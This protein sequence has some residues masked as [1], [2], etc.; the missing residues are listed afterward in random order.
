MLITICGG[1]N[2]AH[3]LAGLLASQEGIRV[4]MYLPYG[5]EAERWRKGVRQEGG[6]RV[7]GAAGEKMGLPERISAD[8]AEVIP[9]SQLVVLAL[10]AFAHEAMVRSMVGYLDRD[11]WIGAF[12]ARGGFDLCVKDVLKER[13]SR[14][15]IFGL[16]TLPWACRIEAFG[17]QVRILGS[18]ARVDVAAQPAGQVGEICEFLVDVLGVPMAA[19]PEFL[20]L[21]LAGTGQIIHPGVMFGLFH[22]WNGQAYEQAPLFYQGIDDFTVGVLQRMSDEIQEVR[23]GLE[24]NFPALDLFAVRPLEEWLLN[25]YAGTIEDAGSLKDC[26]VTN[27]S[28]AGLKAP[29]KPARGGWVPDFQARYLAEDL[30]YALLVTRGIAELAGIATPQIDEV[31]LWGQERLGKTYLSA[32]K[33]QRADLHASHAPQRFGYADIEELVGVYVREGAVEVD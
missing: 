21:T 3:T 15:T 26:F 22:D 18:K 2:A 29:V 20:S 16:Q 10:P 8:A 5:D 28:Y 33:L 13:T 30:P 27:S 32:G 12:P 7:L 6:M 11:V 23:E 19:V 25:A 4:H 14:V 9:G 31:I 17:R 1:G 24:A